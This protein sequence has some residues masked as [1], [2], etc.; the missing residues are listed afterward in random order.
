M[1]NGKSVR[2]KS[3]SWSLRALLFGL[4]SL[5][6]LAVHA[7]E[8]AEPKVGDLALDKMHLLAPLWTSPIVYRESAV[9]LTDEQG[10]PTARLAF[11]AKEILAITSADGSCTWQVGRT[12]TLLDDR[13][14]LQIANP[15]PVESIKPEQLFPPRDAPQ[16]YRHRVGDPETNLLYAPGA[17]FHS[18]NIEVTYVR[19]DVSDD[20]LR[21]WMGKAPALIDA[22]EEAAIALPRTL[23]LLRS[24]QPLKIAISGD[25]ISTGLDASALT[26]A[27]PNQPGYPDLIVAQLQ[28]LSSSKIELVN[29][30]VAGWSVANGVSDLDELLKHDPDLVIIAYGMNDVGR[31]DP[32]WY[33]DQ[34]QTL[35]RRIKEHDAQTEIVLVA[36]MLGNKEWVHTPSEMFP[37]YRDELKQLTG[38]G[39]ALA[40]LTEVWTVMLER[41]HFLDLTGNGLNHPNDCGHRLYAQA[42]LQ[43]LATRR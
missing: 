29:R 12:A 20:D 25:S 28:A 11:R 19:E 13:V 18:H 7:Q 42:I 6:S 23:D 43:L 17:W 30:A 37:L 3:L 27:A 36:T 14:T 31:K 1:V 5:S 8:Q 4:A 34:T 2:E 39:I 10:V 35:I 38:E 40:D 16:S 24:G 21:Q 15:E 26:S 32:Q 9:L 22:G 33:R 41:K